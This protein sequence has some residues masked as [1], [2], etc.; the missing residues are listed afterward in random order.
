MEIIVGAAVIAAAIVVAA[1]LYLFRPAGGGVSPESLG[2]LQGS[3]QAMAGQIGSLTE[4]VNAQ[5]AGLSH[6][7]NAQI[8]SANTQMFE[9]L[10]VQFGESQKLAADIREAVRGQLTEVA[11]RV[12]ETQ[13]ATK[14]VFRIAEQLDGLQRVLTAQKQRG[15]L[16]EAELALI[17]SNI[18]APT[19][20]ELQYKF[21]NGDA[22]D[23]AIKAPEGIIPVDAKFP[24]ENYQRAIAEPDEQ[25]RTTF[26]NA[27]KNDLKNRIDETA[28][29]I[30]PD[31]G[32]V[33]FAFM[34]IPAE[35]IYYDLLVNEVGAVR[36]NTRSLIE[37]AFNSRKVVIVSPTTFAAYLQTVLQGFRAFKIERAAREIA[38]NVEQL[39]RH[40]KAYE[41]YFSKLGSALT[42]TVNHYNAAGKE[43]RKIDKDMLRI[44]GG[45]PGIEADAV[46]RPLLAAD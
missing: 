15:N 10:R 7:V 40:L 32:T 2:N 12:G 13:E 16:G 26:E 6:T 44:T 5:I 25:Q 24:L 22:V 43:L 28:K 29:Y 19:D 20:Y 33:D 31:E 35:A 36:A 11:T 45:R 39:G 3:V 8:G 37:Y 34:F 18:L 23:A 41:D 17:L 46:E 30:R 42:T 9:Q 21:R 1:A 27:F 14:S 4:S 38:Q